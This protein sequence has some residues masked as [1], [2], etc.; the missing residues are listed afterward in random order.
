VKFVV[1][2]Y[3]GRPGSFSADPST[4]Q[5]TVQGRGTVYRSYLATAGK[6]SV[7]RASRDSI[8]GT[9]YANLRQKSGKG[10]SELNGSWSCRVGTG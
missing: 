10:Q 1:R 6:L 2:H 7:L 9:V 3:R 4:V 5:V 8:S